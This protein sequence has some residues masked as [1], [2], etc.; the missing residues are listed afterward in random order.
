MS[1]KKELIILL[2]DIADLMEFDGQNP[3]KVNA[4]KNGANVIRRFEGEIEDKIK[5]GSIKDV[6]GIGKGIQSVIYEYYETGKSTEY[7]KL[8][9]KVPAG[10]MDILSIRGLG[11]KKVK[12]L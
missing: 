5:D 11:A 4:F 2:E 1:L 7:E 3:F 8:N 6:K 10:I 9:E 12:M